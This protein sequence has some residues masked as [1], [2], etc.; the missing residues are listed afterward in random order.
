MKHVFKS[1]KGKSILLSGMLYLCLVPALLFSQ[2]A[3]ESVDL[4]EE[5]FNPLTDDITKKNS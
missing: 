5:G 4:G 1:I 2:G 3:G